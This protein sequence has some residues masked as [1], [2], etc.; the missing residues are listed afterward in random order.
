MADVFWVGD[1]FGRVMGPAPLKVIRDLVARGRLQAL[2]RASRDGKVFHELKDVPEVYEAVHPDAPAASTPSANLEEARRL[3]GE[4]SR[5]R[6][7]QARERLGA[8]PRSSI[9]ECR[10][11]FFAAVK[12]YHPSRLPPDAPVALA[13]AYAGMAQLLSEAMAEI[14]AEASPRGLTYATQEFVGWHQAS[15]GSI[16]IELELG[17]EDVHLFRDCAQAQL[18]NDGFFV[19][20]PK[21]LPLLQLV[22]VE[23]RFKSF[24]HV[25]TAKGRVVI[26]NPPGHPPGLGIKLLSPADADRKFLS[27][28]VRRFEAAKAKPA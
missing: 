7:L 20:S 8:P 27:Y 3:E 15:D 6:Q 16:R 5:L 4:L 28:F 12:R 22:E 19:P 24:S 25:V 9:A 2:T 11:A 23:L 10:A 1:K 13:E 18:S 21:S 26:N 14:E 17:P